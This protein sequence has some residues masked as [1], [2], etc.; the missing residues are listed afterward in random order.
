MSKLIKSGASSFWVI[1]MTVGILG[2]LGGVA[3]TF[4]MIQQEAGQEGEY[5]LAADKLRLLSQELAVNARESVQGEESTFSSIRNDMGSFTVELGQMQ[6]VGFTDEVKRIK[7][8]WAPVM[9]AS[10]TLADAG[11]RI[12]FLN[13]VST[14]LE[15][16]IKH[17]KLKFFT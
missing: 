8:R 5:R 1:F 14:E 2:C 12:V 7:E 10:R 13:S 9:A 15:K 16:N 6:G 11:T 3:Y 4:Y 17:N